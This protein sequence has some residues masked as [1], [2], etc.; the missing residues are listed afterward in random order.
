M[1]F[2]RPFLR[3]SRLAVGQ[4]IEEPSSILLSSRS[5]RRFSSVGALPVGVPKASFQCNGGQTRRY[6]ASA[7]AS[8]MIQPKPDPQG[9]YQA[10]LRNT[11]FTNE[12]NISNESQLI[13]IFRVMDYDG[14]LQAGWQAPFTAE[15]CVE[16]YK[17]IVR[18][19][20]WDNMMYNIQRQGIWSTNL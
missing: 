13:P 11:V 7:A 14:K 10:G 2:V 4:C 8:A 1:A 18:L 16:R 9:I 6:A 3:R 17:F 20:V 12:C 15:E 19:S 5:A